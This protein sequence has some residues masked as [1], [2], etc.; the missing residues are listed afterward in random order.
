MTSPTTHRLSPYAKRVIR[1]SAVVLG[2]LIAVGVTLRYF[3]V[4]ALAANTPK[5]SAYCTERFQGYQDDALCNPPADMSRVWVDT[6]FPTLLVV[7]VLL[8]AI[9]VIGAMFVYI[10]APGSCRN[11]QCPCVDHRRRVYFDNTGALVVS[12]VVTTA[13]IISTT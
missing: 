8:V 6:V 4:R 10:F 1:R 11:R 12:T 7:L 13:T 3:Y 5:V 9:M 2:V